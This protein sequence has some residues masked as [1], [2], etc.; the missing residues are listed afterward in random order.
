MTYCS[1]PLVY[2]L[3]FCSTRYLCRGRR[4]WFHVVNSLHIY[5]GFRRVLV[6]T[7]EEAWLIILLVTASVYKMSQTAAAPTLSSPCSKHISVKNNKKQQLKNRTGCRHVLKHRQAVT[8]ALCRCL[9]SC[10][11]DFCL[12]RSPLVGVEFSF[13]LSLRQAG[14]MVT[15]FHQNNLK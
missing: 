6:R 9:S 14:S 12:A 5:G 3:C 4:V 2:F 13:G 11:A 1:L 15:I 7:G 10:C 8:S